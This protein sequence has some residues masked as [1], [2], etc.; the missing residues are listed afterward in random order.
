MPYP[1]GHGGCIFS[2]NMRAKMAYITKY[3]LVLVMVDS[4][5]L[6]AALRRTW[7]V[8]TCMCLRLPGTA[9]YYLAVSMHAILIFYLL[10]LIFYGYHLR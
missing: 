9:W 1:L 8:D 4:S 6:G 10:V 3:N 7:Y 2:L 5:Y